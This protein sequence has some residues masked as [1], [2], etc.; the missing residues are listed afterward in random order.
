MERNCS[1]DREEKVRRLGHRHDSTTGAIT[2]ATEAAIQL[3]CRLHVDRRVEFCHKNKSHKRWLDPAQSQ[4]ERLI[5][6]KTT[7]ACPRGCRSW[8]GRRGGCGSHQWVYHHEDV[9]G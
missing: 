6:V 4:R 2:N 9:G 1:G 7:Q 5:Y 3:A 8:A